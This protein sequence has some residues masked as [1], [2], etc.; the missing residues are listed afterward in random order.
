MSQNL[1]EQIVSYVFNLVRIVRK[2][3]TS[4]LN[5]LNLTMLQIETLY[6]L[7]HVKKPPTMA[8]IAKQLKISKPTATVHLDRLV[9]LGLVTRQ[10]QTRDR[11]IVLIKLTPKGKKLLLH[12]LKTRKNLT[13]KLLNCL[14]IEDKEK[15]LQIFKRLIAHL[16]N[17]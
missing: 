6:Y 7:L 11:R 8:E 16:E 10:V 2:Q 3:I 1:E 12:K 4:N 5:T 17:Q 9:S 13:K 15:I 14:S